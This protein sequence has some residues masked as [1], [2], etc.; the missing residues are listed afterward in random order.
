MGSAIDHCPL[1][2]QTMKV[3]IMPEKIR[4]QGIQTVIKM[5]MMST[6]MMLAP[7]RLTLSE[8]LGS[9]VSLVIFHPSKA[10]AGGG[11]ACFRFYSAA[12]DD[13]YTRKSHP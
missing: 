5:P 2:Q 13:A 6:R 10:H 1:L 3:V 9:E 12:K 7:G 4:V 11:R 8:E